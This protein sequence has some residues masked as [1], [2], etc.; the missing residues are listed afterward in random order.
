VALCAADAEMVKT[1]MAL[2]LGVGTVEDMPGSENVIWMVSVA[3]TTAWPLP[4]WCWHPDQRS[5]WR[6]F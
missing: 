4:S 2:G 5:G 1:Y 6:G 3:S